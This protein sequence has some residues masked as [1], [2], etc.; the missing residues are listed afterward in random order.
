[1]RRY[2]P[3]IAIGAAFGMH[4][5]VGGLYALSLLLIPGWAV[6]VLAIW[7]LTLLVAGMALAGRQS[8]WVLGVPAVGLASWVLVV[9]LGDRLLGWSA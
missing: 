3:L 8:L 7:W 2:L 4:L 9:G 1:M 5:A 6:A